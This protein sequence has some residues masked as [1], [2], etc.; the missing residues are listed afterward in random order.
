M[1]DSSRRSSCD[2]RCRPGPRRAR[3]PS[4]RARAGRGAARASNR[5]GGRARA[6]RAR[7][8]SA[9]RQCAG[10]RADMCSATFTSRGPQCES[11]TARRLDL[12][13]R[14]DAMRLQAYRAWSARQRLDRLVGVRERLELVVPALDLVAAVL[15]RVE[16]AVQD[17]LEVGELGVDVVVDLERASG[18]SRPGGA[19][20]RSASRVA[21][22]TTSVRETSR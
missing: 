12:W 5:R 21:S 18:R 2:R 19:I 14:R 10:D 22:L 7:T 17:D 11:T 16:R 3:A 13:P 6:C 8:A 9:D 15:D 1:T 20:R 4:L